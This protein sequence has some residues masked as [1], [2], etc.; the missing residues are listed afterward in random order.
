VKAR[1]AYQDA[2]V[3]IHRLAD[4]IDD[5]ELREGFLTAVPVQSVLALS[6]MV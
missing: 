5:D 3:I 2:A 4:T 1:Q 6:E